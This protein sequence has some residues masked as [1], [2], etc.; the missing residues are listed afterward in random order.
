MSDKCKGQIDCLVYFRRGFKKGSVSRQSCPL[1]KA[2][3][4]DSCPWR[5]RDTIQGH[6]RV[7]YRVPIVSLNRVPE[8]HESCPNIW[9]NFGP[10]GDT[11]RFVEGHD[12]VVSLNRVPGS[13]P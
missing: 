8:G 6:D 2:Q 13:C 7:P 3:G 9:A 1:L 12:R 5:S 4:H 11:T 10:F